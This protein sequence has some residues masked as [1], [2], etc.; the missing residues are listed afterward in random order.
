MS[1]INLSKWV[2]VGRSGVLLTKKGVK[3]MLIGEYNPSI[4]LK[5]RLHFPA[6][7]REDL[8]DKF[9]VTKGL[10]NCLFVYSLS[11]WAELEAKIKALPMSRSRTLQRFFFAGAVE[12]EPD[13]Q[14]RILIPANLREYAHL[15]KDVTVVGASVR[16]EIWDS[17]RWNAFNESM[18]SEQLR[19]DMQALNI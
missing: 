11:E 16:A 1:I 7:L 18:S 2:K 12:V 15:D 10:D 6:R 19:S 8:G 5:G 9:I 4:D 17:E 13:K 3:A 14:G